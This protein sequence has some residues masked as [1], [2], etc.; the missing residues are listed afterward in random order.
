MD[1]RTSRPDNHRSGFDRSRDDGE[2]RGSKMRQRLINCILG[3]APQIGIATAVGIVGA[4]ITAGV[5]GALATGGPG[6]LP[7]VAAAVG[8]VLLGAGIFLAVSLVML[9]AL[10]VLAEVL[11][12]Q[13][14][15]AA[16]ARTVRPDQRPV[17]ADDC[18]ICRFRTSLATGGGLLAGALIYLTLLT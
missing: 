16:T 7:A 14:A 4:L 17:G 12:R 5:V 1:G 6:A 11:R 8:P 10:C 13:R 9:V 15:A 18:R 2:T 3:A